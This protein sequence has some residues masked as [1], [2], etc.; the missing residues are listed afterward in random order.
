MEQFLTDLAVRGHVSASTQNQGLNALVFLDTQVLGRE[1]G[2]VDAVRARR[3]KRL[4]VVLAPEEVQ[5][6]LA[7]IQGA[8]GVFLLM[9]Q[10]LYGCGLRLM[11][12]CRLRGKDVSL[13]RGQIVVRGGKGDK[14][15]VVM[16]PKAVRGELGRQL[17][18]RR[19]LHERDLLRGVAPSTCRTP[20]S[21]S[22]P[23]RPG[24]WAG[25]SC[26]PRGGC[27]AARGPAGRGDTTCSPARC[28]GQ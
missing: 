26:S 10:L 2:R 4:P 9:A 12:C 15:R 11:E 1:L 13:E 23:V 20:R 14:D 5:R 19:R 27:R 21:G 28:N 3:P 22:T 8:G 25:S 7:R 18:W 6:V 16:L 24:S 17:E